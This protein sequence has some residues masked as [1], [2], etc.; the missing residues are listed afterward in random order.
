M[1]Y[2]THYL[3]T[4]WAAMVA[5]LLMLRALGSGHR[6]GFVWGGIS[7]VF[8]IAFGVLAGSAGSVVANLLFL[9][10][11]MRGYLTWKPKDEGGA[12]GAE[13]PSES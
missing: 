11:N 4:D 12:P 8:W 13:A 5:T 6:T 10:F 2:I 1:H 3:G 9:G 7:N